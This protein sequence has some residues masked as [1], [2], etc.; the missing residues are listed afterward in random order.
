M[1]GLS[2]VMPRV[3]MQRQ[4]SGR[5]VKSAPAE[6]SFPPAPVST[7]TRC[8]EASKAA[9]ADCKSSPTCPLNT[10]LSGS[11]NDGGATNRPY[12]DFAAYAGSHH[13]GLSS[14]IPCAQWRMLSRVA[15]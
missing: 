2:V 11:M 1:I 6:N 7:A 14:P 13:N 10:R 9:K 15:S 4:S 8:P 12:G 3:V 5:S